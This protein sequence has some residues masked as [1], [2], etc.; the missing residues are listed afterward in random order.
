MLP[1]GTRARG[2][3]SLGR[4]KYVSD[5]GLAAILADIKELFDVPLPASSR[6]SLK[7]SRQEELNSGSSSGQLSRELELT[8]AGKTH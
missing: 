4:G 7:R 1:A 6:Q 2:I 8:S 3:A 5:A